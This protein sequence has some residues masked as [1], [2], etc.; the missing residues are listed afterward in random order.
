MLFVKML[1]I[2]LALSSSILLLKMLAIL[3]GTSL[4]VLANK[5]NDIF[6]SMLELTTVQS[7]NAKTARN[8][9]KLAQGAPIALPTDFF[10]DQG[11][12]KEMW[13]NLSSEFH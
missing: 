12:D 13:G 1:A 4:T 5:I 7:K 3:L 6:A 9:R 11:S 8:V 10:F 2:S